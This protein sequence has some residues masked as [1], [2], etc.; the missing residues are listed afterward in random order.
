M[1]TDI[2]NPDQFFRQFVLLAN[3]N[4]SQIAA[5][6]S[7]ASLYSKLWLDHKTGLVFSLAQ[8]FGLNCSIEYWTIDAV[9]F[10]ELDSEHLSNR[11]RYA[12]SLAIAVEH[13]NNSKSSHEEI[14]KLSIIDAPLRVLIT[15]AEPADQKTLLEQYA[16]QLQA[17]DTFNDFATKRK[18][19]V[20]FGHLDGPTAKWAGLVYDGGEF[21]SLEI[22]N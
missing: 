14:N 9:M 10:K 19:L 15:Y 6:W 17:A 2:V 13:E 8:S 21:T 18:I 11:G 16:K 4:A 3:N 12:K 5:T 22:P 20:I 7:N 1:K